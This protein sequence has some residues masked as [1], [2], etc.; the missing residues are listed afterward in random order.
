MISR[1]SSLSLF[2]VLA[3]LALL[4]GCARDATSVRF[5]QADF[6]AQ[7]PSLQRDRI[8][9]P[10]QRPILPESGWTTTTLPDVMPRPGLF[11]LLQRSEV[12]GAWIT[13]W[14][15]VRW[16]AEGPMAGPLAVYIPRVHPTVGR[17]A[18]YVNGA[19]LDASD[20]EG[21]NQPYFALVPPALLRDANAPEL[22]LH[23]ALSLV[24][25]GGGSIS[26]VYVGP[27]SV[28]LDQYRIR[29]FLQTTMTQIA[30]VSF[31]TMGVFT[32]AFWWFRR[33][34]IE[35]VLF[36]MLATATC[37]RLLRYSFSDPLL[38]DGW[39]AWFTLN[40]SG[41]IVVLGHFLAT[42]LQGRRYPRFE[43]VMLI[44]TLAIAVATLAMPLSGA[45]IHTV[46]PP[47]YVLDYLIGFGV[48]ISMVDSAAKGRRLDG[49]LIA[50]AQIVWYMVSIHD[51]FVQNA[52]IDMEGLFLVPYGALLL[53]AAFLFGVLRRY[54][55]AVQHIESLNASL[56]GA[57]AQRTRELE[58]THARLRDVERNQAISDERQRLMREMHD[59][60]GSSLMSSLVLVEQGE[61]DTKAV[62]NVLRESI[63]DLK[64]TIDSLEPIGEDL[65]TLLGTLRY[66]IGKRLEGAGLTLHWRV[67]DIPKLNWLTPPAALQILR[68]LQETFA[69]IL[70]HA[71]ATTILVAT[72][73][74]D[75][76]VL[77]Q[78]V[79]NGAG[80]DVA[81]A[82]MSSMGRG[83][84]N[85]KRRASSI[86]ATLEIRS[87]AGETSLV[88]GLPLRPSDG[89]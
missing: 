79:D 1:V 31:L 73:V 3:M 29:D 63:D 84:R 11:D 12:D 22:E 50:G 38:L 62:A 21:W 78:V 47:I 76:N 30:A 81:A 64:L 75:T 6:L 71:N 18:V 9:A 24:P 72:T 65:S 83:L 53:L 4:D 44:T 59:G 70:K 8:E 33:R 45:I 68:I 55:S 88:L 23:I 49:M 74:T 19:R 14:Y 16:R 2:A 37:I 69:N 32:F 34:E 41:W 52:G 36:A 87:R 51:G 82:Q 35:Y 57:L 67:S 48:L 80:F 15:R 28:L 60:L 40:A 66:R 39:F 10:A 77:V 5:L 17:L 42:R 46:G 56:E 85:L 7:S 54:L 25:R 86:G 58:A 89:K 20:R 61:M 27:A 13:R 26:T 43:R